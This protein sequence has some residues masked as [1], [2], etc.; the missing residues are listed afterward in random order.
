MQCDGLSRRLIDHQFRRIAYPVDVDAL[1][2]NPMDSHGDV[3]GHTALLLKEAAEVLVKLRGFVPVRVFLLVLHP[4]E[5][6]VYLASLGHDPVIVL[7]EVGHRNILAPDVLLRVDE[8]LNLFRVLRGE[9]LQTDPESPEPLHDGGDGAR[10][11]RVPLLYDGIRFAALAK[12]YHADDT[13]VALH[14]PFLLSK[15]VFVYGYAINF[16]FEKDDE[17]K[18]HAVSVET[19]T[20]C[21]YKDHAV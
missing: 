13:V 4:A 12:G 3:P 17:H 6:D 10:S 21:L 1:A 16:T 18:K 19:A 15:G 14:D 9:F 2:R 11:D 20:P 8:L 7:L 5:R